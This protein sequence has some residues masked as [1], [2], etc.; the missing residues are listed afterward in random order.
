MLP[1]KKEDRS[2]LLCPFY[3][4]IKIFTSIIVFYGYLVN[5]Y[6]DVGDQE[7]LNEF[8]RTEPL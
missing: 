2:D 5:K 8:F 4:S 3:F 1:I 7:R 6:K